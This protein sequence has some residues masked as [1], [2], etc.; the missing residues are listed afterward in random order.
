M[1]V[2]APVPVLDTVIV[3]TGDVVP[4]LTVPNAS[5]VG[6]ADTLGA[7]APTPVPESAIGT[8]TPVPVIV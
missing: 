3:C 2:A 5:A 1:L 4:T 8:L 7:L 6:A